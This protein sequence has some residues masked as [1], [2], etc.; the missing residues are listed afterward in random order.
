MS[1][2][3][4]AVVTGAGSGIGRGAALRLAREGYS[5]GLLDSDAEAAAETLAMVARG[6]SG[7][8][9]AADVTDVEAVQAAMAEFGEVL[10]TPSALVNSAGILLAAPFLDTDLASW[11]RVLEVNVTGTF[12][13]TQA[14]VRRLVAERRPGSVVNVASVHSDAPGTGLAAYDAS[15]GALR[16]LTRSLARELGPHGIRVNAVAPGAVQSRLAGGIGEDYRQALEVALPLGRVGEPEDIAGA[17]AFLCSADAAYMTG[18]MM[19]IDGGMLLT[20]HT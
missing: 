14:V 5:V 13:C 4:V 16:M 10:G 19:V 8:A 7:H 3:A 6:G 12:V 20:A 11:R 18:S 1:A 9:V 2:P 15:K 17:I